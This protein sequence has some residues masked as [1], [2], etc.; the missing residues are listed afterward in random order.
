MAIDFFH[1]DCMDFMRDKPNGFYDLAIVD[2]PYGGSGKENDSDKISMSRR[3]GT[4]ATK[5]GIS[6]GGGINDTPIETWDYAPPKEYFDE[7]FRVSKN[8]IIWGGNYFN[9]PP[10]RCFIIW[11]KL[12]ISEKFTMAMAEYAWTSFN[13]NAKVFECAPQGN[14][15]EPRF[16]LAQKPV[17]LYKWCLNMFAEKGW[18][19]LDT[20]GGS[21][22][23]AV[24]ASELGFDMDICEINDFYFTKGKERVEKSMK[25]LNLF[26]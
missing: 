24:A 23:S 13:K 19:L 2:P 11:K 7:L 6:M 25:Q 17:R 3:G 14:P 21:M 15:K 9:L 18:K 26:K 1:G 20:H 12:T 5:Y 10:C 16:H 8:Q 4:W 22:S